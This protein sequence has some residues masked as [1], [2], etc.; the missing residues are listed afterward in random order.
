MEAAEILR[1]HPNPLERDSAQWRNCCHANRKTVAFPRVRAQSLAEVEAKGQ[2]SHAVDA[3]NLQS[4][5]F[6]RAVPSFYGQGIECVV[7]AVS[8]G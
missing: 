1:I 6:F 3:R 8:S 4:S 2:L 7:R 5:V